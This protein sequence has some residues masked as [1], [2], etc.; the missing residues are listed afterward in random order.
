MHVK[1]LLY[2]QIEIMVAF[3]NGKSEYLF[4]VCAFM[5]M[6]FPGLGVHYVW[7]AIMK[8]S[9]TLFLNPFW[10]WKIAGSTTEFCLILA[11]QVFLVSSYGSFQFFL[12]IEI[13]GVFLVLEK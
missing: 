5:F 2:K 4:N 3:V 1:W 7:R 11:N 13:L 10:L 12:E 6:E 8:E 9:K